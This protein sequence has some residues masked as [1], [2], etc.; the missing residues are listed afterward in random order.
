MIFDAIGKIEMG[1]YPAVVSFSLP[2][3]GIGT[4]LAVFHSLGNLPLEIDMLI[5]LESI[6]AVLSAVCFSIL[7]DMPSQ[8]IDFA[9]STVDR[10]IFVVKIFS[11]MTLTDEN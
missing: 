1:L 3:L 2:G 9:V 4:T 6:G 10:E 11:S 5:S 8:P 7:A